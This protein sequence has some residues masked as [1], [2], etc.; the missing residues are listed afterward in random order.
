MNRD[1]LLKGGRLVRE[2]PPPPA[3]P[4]HA[5]PSR[6][7][8]GPET[9]GDS[10]K[11]GQVSPPPREAASL[12]PSE[13]VGPGAGLA[14]PPDGALA[15]LSP[16]PGSL[17]ES[18]T[19]LTEKQFEF[20]THRL[21]VESDDEAVELMT[22]PVLILEVM[23]WRDDPLFEGVYQRAMENKREAFRVLGTHL[24]PKALRVI[25]KMLDSD[26]IKA[27]TAGLQLLLKTQALLDQPQK[28][29]SEQVTRLLEALRVPGTVV[30][31]AITPRE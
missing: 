1:L 7:S 20:M 27:N 9:A 21:G 12:V 28:D 18:F 25:N 11:E 30:P 23:G 24:L 22:T 2:D 5:S 17:K 13:I 10:T 6:G 16:L 26:S 8:G 19:H 29:Q 31:A 3:P 4:A 15:P 14:L